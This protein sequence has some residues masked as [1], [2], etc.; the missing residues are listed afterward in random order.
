M[1][2]FDLL[3]LIGQTEDSYLAAA[4]EAPPRAL[5][6]HHLR[7]VWLIAAVVSLLALLAGCAIYLLGLR[8]LTF[9]PS[10][11]VDGFGQVFSY[12]PI[13]LQGFENSPN[14]K[15]AKEWLAFCDTYDADER[16]LHSLS[17]D[18]GI[19]PREYDNYLCY[20]PEMCRKVDEICRKYGLDL[21]GPI[22]IEYYR[23]DLLN[24][25]QM[26]EILRT[27]QLRE[28][29]PYAG[30]YYPGGT[31]DLGGAFAL[32]DRQDV[33]PYTI[34]YRL[35]CSMKQAFD[36]VYRSTSSVEDYQE[37]HYTCADGTPLL[38]ALGP[39]DAMIFADREDAFLAVTL[40][41]ELKES[42][43]LD[44]PALE[45]MAEAFDFTV[46][47]RPKSSDNHATNPPQR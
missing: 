19:M 20:T 13:S 14:Y 39:S 18:E 29:V 46:Q 24:A 40:Y 35:R 36:S 21:M 16:I 1:T 41:P 5:R 3:T 42:P 11:D 37:W 25:L 15:A 44:R 43:P 8:N 47:P 6:V 32:A 22:T 17:G 2:N 23:S 4:M 9:G 27:E 12:E 34:N 7:R 26:P 33:Y 31:F 30:Y 28:V 10:Q 45:A 38:L